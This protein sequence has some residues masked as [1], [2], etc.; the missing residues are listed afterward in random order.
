M[1]EHQQSHK[2]RLLA[3]EVTRRCRFNCRHC[4]ADADR[5]ADRDELSTEQWKK[6]LDSVAAY[7][8]CVIILTGD[9]KS[10]V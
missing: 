8:K 9:R 10:V 4:R 1:K 3:F 2:P 6:I 5:A 7:E